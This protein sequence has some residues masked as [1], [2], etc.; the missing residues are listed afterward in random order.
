[1]TYREI[2][3]KATEFIASFEGHELDVL[4]VSRPPDLDYAVHLAKV[5]SKLSPMLGNMIEYRL[6]AALNDQEGFPE[7]K[8]IRQD[9]GFPDTI[10]ESDI[11]PT[12]GIEIKTWFPLATEITARFRD[13][14]TH[15]SEDQT[16][17]AMLAWLPEHLIYGQPKI[18]G[19]WVDTAKSVAE[20]RDRHYHRPPDYLVFEPEDTSGRTRNLQQTN[21]NGYKFQGTAEQLAD[22]E[23]IVADWGDDGRT[24]CA[25][26]VYQ[27]RLKTLLGQFPYR[28][29][30]NFAKMDRIE[31]A[32]L[33]DFKR[34]VLGMRINGKTVLQWSRILRT[35]ETPA[36]REALRQLVRLE[37]DESEEHLF[38]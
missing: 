26:A 9:P 21:C 1:M 14:V 37:Q 18:I 19:T 23:R 12:P 25:D 38:G 31:H 17:V 6:T 24:F 30:T 13:S 8:W 34:R 27:D 36:H 15:F 28:L 11:T 7:G 20:A 16:N 29:D 22:A 5:I 35:P 2:L 4:D 10:F 32:T 33:E 3:A